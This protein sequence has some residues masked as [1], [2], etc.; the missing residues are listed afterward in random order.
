MMAMEIQVA[1]TQTVTVEDNEVPSITCP[2]DLTV[3]TDAGLCTA[4]GVTLRK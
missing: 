1:C 4:S 2:S 3:D